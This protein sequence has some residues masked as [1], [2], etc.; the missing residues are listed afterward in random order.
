MSSTFDMLEE[1]GDTVHLTEQ[2]GKQKPL[3]SKFHGD[4]LYHNLICNA[5]PASAPMIDIE[6]IASNSVQ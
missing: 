4:W 1:V 2:H 6:C 5:F 3:G